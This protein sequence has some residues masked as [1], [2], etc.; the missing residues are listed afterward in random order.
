MLL[1]MGA[2]I[3]SLVF[4]LRLNTRGNFVLKHA[5]YSCRRL[6]AIAFED[7]LYCHHLVELTSNLLQ[8]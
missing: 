6:H 7:L 4:C 8:G 1:K 2:D 5:M 3:A